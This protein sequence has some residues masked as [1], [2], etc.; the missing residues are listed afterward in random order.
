MEHYIF[1]VIMAAIVLSVLLISFMMIWLR[2]RIIIP[3]KNIESA[4]SE[5][6]VKSRSRKDPDALVLEGMSLSRFPIPC[7]PC[8]RI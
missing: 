7:R 8:Q 5:F 1:I 4:A 2:K 3:L 6:E